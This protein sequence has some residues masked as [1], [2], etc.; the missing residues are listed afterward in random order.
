MATRKSKQPL[1]HCGG[2][3]NES[4]YL[5]WIRSALRSKW[6][7]WQ[8]RNDCL[9]ASRRTYKGPNKRQKWEYQC[10][11]CKEWYISKAMEVDHYP[12]DA[13]TIL[14]VE[15]IGPFAGRLFC[16]IDNLRAVCKPCHKI[17]TYAQS[18]GLTFEEARAAK[19][20][21]EITKKPV[22][23]VLAF[24]ASHGYTTASDVSNATKRKEL[25]TKILK[26]NT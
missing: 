20:V 7:R 26:G 18:E 8:P 6:L 1:T 13:G 15:D 4:Q 9:A 14:T 22:K 10:S 21:I 12:H 19:Q 17:H 2:T 11:L 3:M 16:E 24:L 5:A 23:Q 25:V